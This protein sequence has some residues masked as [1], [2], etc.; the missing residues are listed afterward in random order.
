MQKRGRL[1]GIKRTLSEWKGEDRGRVANPLGLSG[2]SQEIHPQ[3]FKPLSLRRWVG[4]VG[5]KCKT[6]KVTQ[7]LRQ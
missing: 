6:Y 5:G 2:I 1:K 7:K 3:D 4:K